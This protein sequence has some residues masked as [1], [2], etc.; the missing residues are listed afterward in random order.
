MKLINHPKGLCQIPCP[1]L[2][3]FA[4]NSYLQIYNANLTPKAP[5]IK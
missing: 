1:K 2:S 5:L 4:Q 3:S